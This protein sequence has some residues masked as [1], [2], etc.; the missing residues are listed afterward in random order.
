MRQM[1]ATQRRTKYR[2]LEGSRTAIWSEMVKDVSNNRYLYLLVVPGILY[3]LTFKYWP[4]WG[5]AIAFKDYQPFV[6][7]WG[8]PWVGLKHFDRFFS[9]QDFWLLFRNTL[10]IAIYKILF[11]FPAPIIVALLLNEVRVRVFK[12]VVQTVVYIPHFISWVVVVGITY[13]LFTTQDGIVNSILVSLGFQQVDFLSSPHWFRTMITT[14][15]IWKETGWG[16]IL[17]LAAMTSID[18]QLYEAARMDGAG[19]L[20]Q[21]WHVTLP[22]IRSTIVVLFILNLGHFMDNGFDQIY[23][24]LNPGNSQ[25]GEVFDTYV[26]SNG[27]ARGQFSYSTAVGLFKSLVSLILVIGA[28]TLTRKLGEEGI[29]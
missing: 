5:V 9:T 23:N 29:Y 7:F 19:R 17:Y 16:T 28:N 4:M 11:Y 1:E 13:L 24:M 6:G 10:V 15:T 14:Q 3:F 18:S 27:I 12:R 8:S 22:G 21:M 25:V 20:R 2:K 26:Y